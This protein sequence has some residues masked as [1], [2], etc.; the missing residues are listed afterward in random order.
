M[1]HSQL[2]SLTTWSSVPIVPPNNVILFFSS[3]HYLYLIMYLFVY[4]LSLVSPPSP[5]HILFIFKK[6]LFIYFQREGKGGRKKGRKTSMCG[7]LFCASSWG[8]GLQPKRV[9]WLG[10]KPAT[11]WFRGQYSIHWATP[12]RASTIYFKRSSVNSG[13]LS[14]L[15]LLYLDSVWFGPKRYH[16]SR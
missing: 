7:C 2:Y 16:P 3:Q 14:I 4:F 9:P 10:I 6:I 8:L 12:A 11:L 1:L 13:T 15:S 5:L